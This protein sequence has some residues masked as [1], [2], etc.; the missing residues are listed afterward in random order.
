MKVDGGERRGRNLQCRLRHP[1][2][3]VAVDLIG[4]VALKR[5]EPVT[6][7]AAEI[8]HASWRESRHH[9]RHNHICRSRDVRDTRLALGVAVAFGALYRAIPAHADTALECR[10][11]P[12]SSGGSAG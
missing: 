3:V 1:H 10:A 4:A 2:T 11:R 7:A 5:F 8:D 9:D 12:L 6:G